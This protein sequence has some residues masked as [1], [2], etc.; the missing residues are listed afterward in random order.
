MVLVSVIVTVPCVACARVLL[1]SGVSYLE[2]GVDIARELTREPGV[3]KLRDS[4]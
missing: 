1:D 3:W 2:F 4:L